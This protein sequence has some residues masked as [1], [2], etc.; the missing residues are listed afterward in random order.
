MDNPRTG[1]RQKDFR[2]NTSAQK[3]KKSHLRLRSKDQRSHLSA[4]TIVVHIRTK[5]WRDKD[6]LKGMVRRAGHM[7]RSG[8]RH[9]LKV[10]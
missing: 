7:R 8:R 3:D 6:V 1:L 5:K 10:R 9:K 4:T 2:F